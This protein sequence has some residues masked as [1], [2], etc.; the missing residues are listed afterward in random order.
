MIGGA[1]SRAGSALREAAVAIA[2][3]LHRRAHAVAIAEIDVVAHADLVAVV[4]DRRAGQREEQRVQQLDPAAAVFDQRREAAADA[5]VDPHL[6]I[7]GVAPDTCSRALRR[8]PSRASARRGCGGRAP[9]GSSRECPASGR[10]I[11]AIGM[12]V[13]LPERHEH[14]RHQREVERHV[15]FVAVAEVGRARRPATGWPRR[16]ACG[17]RSAASSARRM[18]LRIACV[19][20]RFSLFVPSRSNRYGTASSRS[21]STPRS[22]QNCIDVDDGVDDAPGCRSSGRADARRSGASSTASRSRRTSSS[23]SRC[24]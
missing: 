21:A 17:S 23:T 8:S 15:A 16:G 18:R 7:G 5:D 3:P 22:S 19:S 9:T 12:A 1:N 11:S 2:G 14:A 10:R 6:R 20:G 4:D 13:L 24:R